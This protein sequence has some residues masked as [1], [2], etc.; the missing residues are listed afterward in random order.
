MAVL[1][2]RAAK[3]LAE[4][5]KVGLLEKS[6]MGAM[7]PETFERA[8]AMAVGDD[9]AEATLAELQL[10]LGPIHLEAIQRFGLY[11][12]TKVDEW[13]LKKYKVTK[14]ARRAL[15]SETLADAQEV[16]PAGMHCRLTGPS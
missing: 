8:M 10:Y 2:A 9:N 14:E 6:T 3:A 11:Q 16:G 7:T 4:L 5:D 13:R 15:P 1:G 12:Q